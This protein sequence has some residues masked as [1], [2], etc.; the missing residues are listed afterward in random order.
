MSS[1]QRGGVLDKTGAV[2]FSR[3]NSF[4]REDSGSTAGSKP[5][6]FQKITSFEKQIVRNKDNLLT[7]E[8][9]ISEIQEKL[10]QRQKQSQSICDRAQFQN[11]FYS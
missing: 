5:Y 1:W 3:E 6:V 9:N 2:T 4:W 10:P 8:A 7:F 11:T